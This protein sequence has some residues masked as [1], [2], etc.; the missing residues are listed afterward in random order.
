MAH[1]FEH[2]FGFVCF[3]S[4]FEFTEA[5]LFSQN[6]NLDVL[7]FPLHGLNFIAVFPAN[8][9]FALVLFCE[10][11]AFNYQKFILV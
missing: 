9:F 5:L 1:L 11:G 3:L 6:N 7:E 10:D 4:K 2:P 8:D